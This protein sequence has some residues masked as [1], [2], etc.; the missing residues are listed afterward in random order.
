MPMCFKLNTQNIPLNIGN[1]YNTE[2]NYHCITGNRKLKF[3]SKFTYYASS[4]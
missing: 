3:N 4:E 1:Y 2:I